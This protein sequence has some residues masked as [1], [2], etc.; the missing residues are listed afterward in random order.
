MINTDIITSLRCQM[1]RYP[2]AFSKHIPN[3]SLRVLAVRGFILISSVFR[4]IPSCPRCSLS[5]TKAVI[6]T[7]TYV[8]LSLWSS[9]TKC[10]YFS[11]CHLSLHSSYSLLAMYF[12]PHPVYIWLDNVWFN[13]FSHL[14]LLVFLRHPNLLKVFSQGIWGED[15]IRAPALRPANLAHHSATP[16]L[17]QDCHLAGSGH[18]G[19]LHS[20]LT[21]QVSSANQWSRN[22]EIIHY[23]YC[24]DRVPNPPS[25]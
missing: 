13:S 18:Q 22:P 11:L 7:V 24:P 21:L 1:E 4:P 8:L 15:G 17:P 10:W 6:T 2:I 5:T 25:L 20:T 14:P 3:R 12:T 16:E 19:A 23:I 9:Q